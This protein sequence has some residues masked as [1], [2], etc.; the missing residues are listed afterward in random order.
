MLGG[1]PEIEIKK[2]IIQETGTYDDF[3]AR[4]YSLTLSPYA[5]NQVSDTLYNTMNSDNITG[6]ALAG[7]TTD[8]LAPTA[9]PE[10]MVNIPYGWETR[11]LKFSMEVHEKRGGSVFIYH[12][13]GYTDQPGITASG[14]IDPEM[15]FVI[16]SYTR[17]VRTLINTDYGTTLSDRVVES[18]NIINTEGYLTGNGATGYGL[19]PQDVFTGASHQNMVEGLR[20]V[21]PENVVYDTRLDFDTDYKV[22][23]RNNNIPTSYLSNILKNYRKSI[24]TVECS[25]G[26]FNDAYNEGRWSS[27]E[28]EFGRIPFIRSLAATQGLV[29]T[30]TFKIG[31]LEKIDATVSHRVAYNRISQDNY[32]MLPYRGQMQHW[33]GQD[34]TTQVATILTNAIPGLMSQLGLTYIN[35]STTNEDEFGVITT[36]IT[37]IMDLTGEDLTMK[38]N[39]FKFILENEILRDISFN[40]EESFRINV[41]SH[42]YG[43]TMLSISL[44][45]EAP[46]DYAAPTFCDSLMAPTLT[47]NRR[48]HDTYVHEFVN[49]L[50]NVGNVRPAPGQIQI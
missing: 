18:C 4:P 26:E 9:A 19:R 30:T 47:Y 35:F 22:S 23:R 39:S 2:L 40:F 36:I 32:G 41:N 37:N 21:N 33:L 25:F 16:N 34:R 20:N 3:Y 42:L 12:F 13:Q 27:Q 29:S 38:A 15:L 14:Y 24:D 43:D 45:G 50:N 1:Q 8:M 11:R 44:N 17:I 46:V 28:P 10:K 49:L 7:K 5:I 6:R 48:A 31:D